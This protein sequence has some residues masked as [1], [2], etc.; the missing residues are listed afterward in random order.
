[1]YKVLIIEDEPGVYMTLEDRLISEGYQVTVKEDGIS[2]ETEAKKGIYD[3]I[4]LD[5]MLPGRDGFKVCENLRDFGI[6]SPIIMLT[7][8]NTDL[9]T[10]IGLRQGADDYISKPFEMSILLARME[11]VL[12][13]YSI[14]EKK[15]NPQ[16]NSIIFGNF[17]LN[18]DRGILL[19]NGVEIQ[20]NAQEYRLLE[21]L[22]INTGKV[23]DRNDILDVVWGYDNESTSRTIDVHIAKLRHKLG[24]SEI[25]KHIITVRGRGYRFD[26]TQNQ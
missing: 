2:G 8:R 9:D 24:E 19:K 3:L 17:E 20:L 5:V 13:R 26:I 21:F 6:S 22:A 16:T 1:M 7:A 15:I 23:M 14:T 11:A 25:P 10:I 4:L 12:R 18:R